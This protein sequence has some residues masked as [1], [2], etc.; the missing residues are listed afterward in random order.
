[1]KEKIMGLKNWNDVAELAA[2]DMDA[3]E[4]ISRFDRLN[5]L[6]EE[7]SLGHDGFQ[8]VDTAAD[9]ADVAVEPEEDEGLRHVADFYLRTDWS[10][11]AALDEAA[12]RETAE[13]PYADAA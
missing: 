13:E 5:K 10:P 6:A 7:V 1:M 3:R 9:P 11:A 2:I 4:G 8:P 12:E